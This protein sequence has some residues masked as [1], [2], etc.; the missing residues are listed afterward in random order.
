MSCTTAYAEPRA[1]LAH[2]GGEDDIVTLRAQLA[3]AQAKA[4]SEATR[5]QAEVQLRR[6]AEDTAARAQAETQAEALQR[7]AAQA[8]G[9]AEA[10]LRRAA[11]DVAARAQAWAEAT[12][13]KAY[14]D[15]F[16]GMAATASESRGTGPGV[17]VERRG[18]PPLELATL[19]DVLQVAA[20]TADQVNGDQVAWEQLR[21]SALSPTCTWLQP[22]KPED[23]EVAAVHPPVHKV[24][25]AALP[26]DADLQIF[27]G[28]VAVD[29]AGVGM[30]P[31]FTLTHVRDQVANSIGALL[32]V[33]VKLPKGMN[34]AL[35]QA[36]NCGRRR[37]FRLVREAI[38]RGEIDSLHGLSVMVV[39]TDGCSVAL[40]RIST[41]APAPG[42][43]FA[44]ATPCK[45]WMSDALP[46]L[47][48]WHT[49]GASA[50]PVSAPAGFL[51]LRQLLR[52]GAA[53]LGAA[54]LPLSEVRAELCSAPVSGAEPPFETRIDLESRLGSGGFCD[55]YAIKAAGSATSAVGAVLKLPRW[56]SEA[57]VKQFEAEEGTLLALRGEPGVPQLLYT[58][59]L[60]PKDPRGG[61]ARWPLLILHPCGRPLHVALSDAEASPG[62]SAAAKR[63]AF[64]AG[65]LASVQRALQAAHA[66]DIVHC[67]VRPQNVV[68]VNGATDGAAVLVDWGLARERGN[69]AAGVGVAAY[70]AS[71]VFLE[72]SCAATESLDLFGAALLW[73]CIVYGDRCE[74]PWASPRLSDEAVTQA[75]DQW[76]HRHAKTDAAVAA[77]RD[78]L[79]EL[80]EIRGPLQDTQYLWAPPA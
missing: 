72:A 56:A 75:R 26:E 45:S 58:G 80:S 12:E 11:E 61:R 15:L 17:D 22:L 69:G 13:L 52:N 24:L 49:S 57:Q 77:V 25:E 76:L 48:K 41:G 8:W 23:S 5:A 53:G 21:S 4:E 50:L 78:R 40:V 73:V 70:A 44:N 6:A 42:G 60:F 27:R 43:S 1:W 38:K 28:K 47:G 67:D 32:M 55:A 14:L 51:A 68:A 74:A 63:R 59:A 30:Q 37:L 31:D 29:S 2:A 36:A 79:K 65:V 9:E 66:A 54:G 62:S 39:A 7:R 71:R 10:Q 18:A 64:A 34:S 35:R 46:L 16:R 20:A 19:S 33:E 3:A